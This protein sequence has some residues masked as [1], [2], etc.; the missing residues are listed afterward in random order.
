MGSISG[1]P[2]PIPVP[3]L[4]PSPSS[5]TVRIVTDITTVPAAEW[6][7]CAGSDNPFLAHEFLAA[8][9]ESGSVGPRT[10][11]QPQHLAI[12][13]GCGRVVASVAAYLKSHSYGEYVFD[14]G[15]A[16]AFEQAGGRYYPKLQVSVPF[17]PASGPRLL[18]RPGTDADALG[19]ALIAGLEEVA[20]ERKASSVHATF[21]LPDDQSRFERSGWLTRLGCQYHWH[22]RGYAS[23][24][25]FLGALS[26]RKRKA[27]RKERQEVAASGIE[28]VTLTGG[29]LGR[30]HWDA[31][32]RFYIDTSDRK[33]G[34]PY[35]NRDFFH[36]IGRTMADRAV[37]VMAR[38]GGRWVAGAL[39]F[40]GSD[41]LYG[42]NWGSTVDAPFLHFEAC[43][44]RAIDFAIERGLAR[45]EA[46]AQGEHKIQR[47]YLPSETVSAHWIAH[48][49]L[50]AAIEDFLKRE[51]AAMKAEIAALCELSPFRKDSETADPAE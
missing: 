33:W 4:M 15:W 26:S 24:D 42:R 30:E 25:D 28:L 5:L 27:I 11:W 49:G 37:L 40:L 51:R 29:D 46:G 19:Q 34:S 18:I 20:V 43:Y 38:Q 14:Q 31:F 48:P 10:G 44:Y 47:G 22:N 23:F 6:D 12:A 41:T 21:L 17:T 36:R 16:R 3:P 50:A 35:L 2:F 32:F 39:N 7:A 9:E 45:V 8:L 1:Q 13:N